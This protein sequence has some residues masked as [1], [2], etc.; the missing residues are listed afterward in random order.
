[1]KYGIDLQISLELAALA[2]GG[3]IFLEVSAG[4]QGRSFSR[5]RSLSH[6]TGR[7]PSVIDRPS[8]VV[9]ICFA[10]CENRNYWSPAFSLCHYSPLFTRKIAF[11]CSNNSKPRSNTRFTNCVTSHSHG[12][13]RKTQNCLL[14]RTEVS[15]D[16][17]ERLQRHRGRINSAR[18]KADRLPSQAS[19]P[20]RVLCI[21]SVRR[22]QRQCPS[23]SNFRDERPGS[24]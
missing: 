3:A 19:L 11:N 2:E 12:G 20:N 5:D 9:V 7:Y 24:Q 14:L 21:H 17:C 23:G 16:L 13:P 6:K 8:L 10:E 22:W 15:P 18:P 1:M 4:F